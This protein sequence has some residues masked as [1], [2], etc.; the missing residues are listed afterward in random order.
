MKAKNFVETNKVGNLR[1]H[2]ESAMSYF[3]SR[4]RRITQLPINDKTVDSI[5]MKSAMIIAVSLLLR[6][7]YTAYPH[8]HM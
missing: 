4:T 3:N 5:A 2:N 1:Q 6:F 7:K 8:D